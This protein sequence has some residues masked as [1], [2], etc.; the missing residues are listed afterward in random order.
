MGHGE[1]ETRGRG[2]KQ[3]CLC[4]VLMVCSWWSSRLLQNFISISQWYQQ[5]YVLVDVIL[6]KVL[7]SCHFVNT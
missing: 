1:W 2:E 3:L 7:G 5:E 6:I 4:I